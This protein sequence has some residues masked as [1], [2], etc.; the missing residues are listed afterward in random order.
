VKFHTVSAVGTKENETDREHSYWY[1]LN[2]VLKMLGTG[3][4]RTG[5]SKKSSIFSSF[6]Q[7]KK[8]LVYQDSIG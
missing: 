6:L 3:S 1:R 2:I 8:H 4:T 5:I 7:K